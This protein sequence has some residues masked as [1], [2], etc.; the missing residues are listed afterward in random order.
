MGGLILFSAGA[1]SKLYS[2][3][4]Y[5]SLSSWLEIVL[6]VPSK[7]SDPAPC[8]PWCWVYWWAQMSFL[9]PAGRRPEDFWG[10]GFLM[11]ASSNSGVS[12]ATW[13]GNS[14]Y[15]HRQ[16]TLI[17]APYSTSTGLSR[18]LW[19]ILWQIWHTNDSSS[20][21]GDLYTGRS[22]TLPM[23]TEHGLR[24]T[25]VH[26]LGIFG[27]HCWWGFPFLLSAWVWQLVEMITH[28][29]KAR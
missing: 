28:L 17:M 8:S 14:M 29:D 1:V 16:L 25:K 21:W 9:Q 12:M 6:Y 2:L 4:R 26:A 7:W 11:W 19:Q 27:D 5:L 23:I 20:G 22:C 13:T 24:S 18:T 10:G 3:T 15:V